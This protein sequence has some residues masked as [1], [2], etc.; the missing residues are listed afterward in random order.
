MIYD[1]SGEN[2]VLRV[3]GTRV[4]HDGSDLD[5][6]QDA[7]VGV[8]L[9]DG[10]QHGLESLD[11]FFFF[12]GTARELDR[13]VDPLAGRRRRD[14]VLVHGEQAA[15]HDVAWNADELVVLAGRGGR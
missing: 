11:T 6:G 4:Q 13:S 14:Q 8:G 7:R 2:C 3:A 5:V 12:V 10:V 9:V 1:K 15:E